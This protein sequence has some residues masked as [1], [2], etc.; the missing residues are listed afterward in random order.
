M[1]NLPDKK[2]IVKF[3]AQRNNKDPYTRRGG[4]L[5][6]SIDITFR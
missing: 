3:F 4:A 6:Q 2:E 5:G 1:S